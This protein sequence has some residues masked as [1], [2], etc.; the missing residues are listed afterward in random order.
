[1]PTLMKKFNAAHIPVVALDIPAPGAYFVG[2]PNRK[3]G[4]QAGE[5]LGNYAK[6]HWSCKPDLVILLDAPIASKIVSDLRVGGVEQGLL[7][8]C[9]KLDKSVIVRRDG[10]GTTNTALPVARDILTANPTAQRILIS[11]MNDVS[12]VGGINAAEQLGRTSSL[13][14]WGQDGGVLTAGN[15]DP[16]LAGSVLY[17]L[18]GYGVYVFRLLDKLAA[19]KKVPMGDQPNSKHATL[20]GSC[21]VTRAQ[22]AKIPPV[23]QRAGIILKA[24]ANAT[25]AGL[26]CPKKTS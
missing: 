16:L 25:A 5:Q 17:F 20:V 15:P 4:V 3:S 12:V 18:E 1:M 14:A 19:G 11:G 6:K 13:F 7:K 21:A 10:G 23:S 9:P 2:A 8:V 26:F 24:P 22:A